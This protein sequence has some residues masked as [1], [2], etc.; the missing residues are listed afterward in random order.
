MVIKIS[1][2]IG[3]HPCILTFITMIPIDCK[4]SNFPCTYT[5]NYSTTNKSRGDSAASSIKSTGLWSLYYCWCFSTFFVDLG[6]LKGGS[7]ATR[8]GI[9]LHFILGL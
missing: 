3:D 7:F 1:A 8:L 6:K 4:I 5:T 2:G 9:E